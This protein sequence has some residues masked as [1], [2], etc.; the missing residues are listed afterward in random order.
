MFWFSPSSEF[1]FPP[2]VSIV[3]PNFVRS[4]RRR[5]SPRSVFSTELNFSFNLT[6]ASIQDLQ[7]TQVTHGLILTKAT[8][9]QR[10]WNVVITGVLPTPLSSKAQPVR[11]SVVH[12]VTYMFEQ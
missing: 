1:V 12:L 4:G 9:H 5:D 7:K 6:S 11:S 10:A 3:K 8:Q 2:Y